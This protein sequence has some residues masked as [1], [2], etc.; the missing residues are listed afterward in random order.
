MGNKKDV[1]PIVV[2]SAVALVITGIVR[3]FI[4]GGTVIKQQP[5]KKELSLPDIPLMIKSE[6]RKAKEIQVLVTTVEIKKD[7]KIV[8][9]KLNWRTWPENAI[10]PSFIAQD[11]NGNPLNNKTDYNNALKMWAKNDIPL[12]IPLTISMLTSTD[13]V[14][15][16]KK[17]KAAKEAEEAKNKKKEEKVDQDGVLVRVGYR[18]VPFQINSKTP[19]SSNMIS[20]GDY[21]DV[22]INSFENNKRKTH[23]YK[24]MKILAID[25]V[26]NKKKEE[27]K[28]SGGLFGG[29]FSLGGLMT[30]KN[31]TL[32][33]KESLVNTMLKQ[34]ENSGITITLRSQSEEVDD[35]G[36]AE[37]VEDTSA[38]SD[39]SLIKDIFEMGRSSSADILRETAKRV[40]RKE[41]DITAWLSDMNNLS[42]QTTR[43]LS[44]EGSRSADRSKK[45][46]K[47]D[48]KSKP[49]E[50]PVKIYRKTD[51]PEEILFGKDGKEIKG[52]GGSA[53]G[54]SSESS[55]V[56]GN[57]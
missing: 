9:S 56:A 29:S 23:V 30:P 16:A 27:K 7:E 4:P 3:H 55:T 39:T 33:V 5:L 8:Q 17:E 31:V 51:K 41:K 48:A 49:A 26:T 37:E 14:E 28:S 11:K 18:A 15:T 50:E 45:S 2:A 34:A 1:L 10:Q 38:S 46:D 19:I 53:D 22:F 52:G 12:G 35:D 47:E 21:V 40:Q 36:G 24:G 57:Y 43:S 32:E 42:A 6:Q 20:P 13:P 44:A 54:G 25:G